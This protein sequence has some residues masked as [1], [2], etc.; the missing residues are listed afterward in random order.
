MDKP[1]E[2]TRR[3]RLLLRVPEVADMLGLS[4]SKIYDLLETGLPFVKI[5]RAKRIPLTELRQWLEE[6]GAREIE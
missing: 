3:E 2:T 4:R 1:K 6:L 5:G